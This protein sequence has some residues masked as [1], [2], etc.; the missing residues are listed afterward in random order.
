VIRVLV[1]EDHPLYRDAL[2]SAL[3]SADDIDVVGAVGGGRAAVA[4]AA[5]TSPD[6]VVMDLGMPDGGG[7]GATAEILATGSGARVLVLTSA[8]DDRNV[9]AALRAGAHGYLLKTASADEVLAAVVAL[10][11]GDGMFS[12]TV[13]DRIVRHVATGGRSG[14]AG[15][16]PQLTARERD[17]L[18][19]MAQGHS[20]TYIA[21]LHVLSLKTVR[22][23]VS[24]VLGKLGA[25][26]R[27]EAV[28]R[29][30]DAGL[31]QPRP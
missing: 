30:R 27:A 5:R 28:A 31:G 15:A 17:V 19:L 11:R 29:A 21:D 22:N 9:Y 18:E 16:F 23:H 4:E 25:A 1:A 7:L 13:V 8:D 20:N 26:S 14:A 3:R 10:A 24:A 6:V 2:V 12:G